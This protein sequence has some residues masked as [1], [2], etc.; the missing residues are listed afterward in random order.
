L[1]AGREDAEKDGSVSSGSAQMKIAPQR[2]GLVTSFSVDNA[3]ILYL[4][5]ATFTD[6]TQNVRG[7]IPLLFPHAGPTKGSL[8]HLSQHG[9]V[10]RMPWNVTGQDGNSITLQLLSND[11]TRKDFSFDFELK[12]KAAVSA[13]TLNHTFTIVNKGDKPMPT[14]YGTHP[15]F[16]ILQED[17]QNLTANIDGFNPKEIDWLGGFDKS[18]VNPGRI[19][20]QIPGK[21]LTLESDPDIFRVVRIW[22]LAGKDFI[23][24]EP[25]TRDSFAIDD[26]GQCLWVGPREP[27][28]L[29][30]AI[31]AE[32]SK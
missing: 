18:F 10:R 23:C 20:I 6:L 8:Y 26:P 17:K 1:S 2:G 24:I 25:W 5:R 4:D 7:G 22:H 9:F 31:S 32:I 29:T 13:N 21:K 16:K 27:I 14:A 15:Y 3:E 19:H 12:L 11:E 30:I 28:N